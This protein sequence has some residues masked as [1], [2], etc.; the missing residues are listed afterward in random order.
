M[1]QVDVE[2]AETLPAWLDQARERLA[3]AGVPSPGSEAVALAR[4]TLGDDYVAASP[5]L[6]TSEGLASFGVALERRCAR[7]PLAR[8]TG[9]LRFRGLEL[10][11]GPGVFLPQPETS[12]MIDW[13]V[14]AIA[15]LSSGTG[16]LLCV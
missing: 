14:A 8:L 13:T 9:T 10:L 3:R 11:V 2:Q 12:A 16:R 7:L 15:G 1:G 4:H 6:P 5:S